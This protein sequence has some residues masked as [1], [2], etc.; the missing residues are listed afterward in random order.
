MPPVAAESH[1]GAPVLYPATV[2]PDQSC[3]SAEDAAVSVG[4]PVAVSG[5]ES[6]AAVRRAVSGA[7]TAAANRSW[8]D[9]EAD[10]YYTEHGAFLGDAGFVWGPEGWTE[11]QLDLLAARPGQR[12]L[13]IGAGAAQCGRWLVDQRGVTVVSSDISAG[14]LRVGARIS[15]A[16]GIRLPLVQ[17]D[18]TALPFAEASFDTVFT[19]YGAVPFVAD[20]GRLM[21]EAARVVRPG[22]RF[23]FSTTHPI[24]WAFPDE[25][26]P[27]GLTAALSYFDRTPYAET[28]AGGTLT[29][30][31][32]HRTLG[33]RVREIVA[34]GL[35]LTDL[36]EPE[37]PD[38]NDQ[39]WGGWSPLRGAHLPGTAIFVTRKP[40]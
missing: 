18:A 25:P 36:V 32:H 8:W 28:D 11:E 34:A 4:D 2:A 16:R 27:A 33:D 5:D 37:W 17:C 40:A 21:R 24:R 35:V 6:Y 26:G 23:V 3:V 20:S 7:A 15:R 31:E 10:D 13:E 39:T 12:L 14:M 9:A 19:S 22:G 38:W 29:Y 1:T 30:A